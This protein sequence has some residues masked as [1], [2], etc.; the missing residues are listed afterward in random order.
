MENDKEK[1]PCTVG[2]LTHNSGAT[3]AHALKSLEGFGEIIIADGGSTDNTLAIARGYG[4][5]I[6]SQSNPGHPITDF[7]LERNR[8]LDAAT[9]DWFFYLDSDEVVS[10]D[11]REEIRRIVNEP[12]PR[13]LV[14]SVRYEKTTPD[15]SVFYK[16]AKSYYQNR[17]FNKKSGA[18]FKRRMHERIVF[19]ENISVG[20]IE[21]SWYVPLDTQLDFSVYREKIEYRIGIMAEN[22]EF[23]GFFHFI[24]RTILDTL[25]EVVKSCIKI[26]YLALRNDPQSI[27]PRYELYRMYSHWVTFKKLFWRYFKQ[28]RKK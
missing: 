18:R 15:L 14:Y 12:I 28:K 5:K 4:C 8:T 11:L 17:F 21:A 19:P 9:Y 3:L 10:H 16:T 23:R 27:P 26:L 2:I 20:V 24:Q 7:S 1:I 22:T 13:Y 6:I 25:I